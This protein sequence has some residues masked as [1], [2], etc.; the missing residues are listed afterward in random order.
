M[1]LFEYL[2][3]GY[4]LMLSFAVVRAVSGVPH[5]TRYPRRYWVHVSWLATALANRS[6][7]LCPPTARIA[8]GMPSGA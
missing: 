8:S 2:A 4:I 3:A 6:P 5:A 7:R 1:S